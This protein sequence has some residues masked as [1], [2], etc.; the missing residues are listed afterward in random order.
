MHSRGKIKQEA[1]HYLYL[2]ADDI[3]FY[4]RNR[5]EYTRTKELTIEFARSQDKFSI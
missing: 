2:F 1:L 3:I 5:I 4:V